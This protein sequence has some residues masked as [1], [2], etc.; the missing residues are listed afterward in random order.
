MRD[1]ILL[2]GMI[3]QTSPVNDYDRRLVVLTKERGKVTIFARGA[4][5]QNSKLTAAAN[6]FC[7]GVFKVYEGKSAYN[8]IDVEVRYYFEELRSNVEGAYLGMYFLEYAAWYSRENNDELELLKLLFQSVRAIVKGTIDYRLIRRIFEIKILAV[9]G[10]F[11]GLSDNEACLEATRYTVNFIVNTPVEKLY[12]FKVS[13]A[14]LK[15]LSV[16]CERCGKRNSDHRFKSLETLDS[17]FI[18]I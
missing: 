11:P 14:V 4:R 1:N 13:D 15:E 5:R 6:P 7:F 12:T 10:E 17:L 8:L 3:L 18:K 9:N 2:T 16:L